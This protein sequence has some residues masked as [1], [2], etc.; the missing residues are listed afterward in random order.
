MKGSTISD[1][2]EVIS[3]VI[4]E[5]VAKTR[6]CTTSVSRQRK[7]HNGSEVMLDMLNETVLVRYLSLLTAAV[8]RGSL[9]IQ[10]HHDK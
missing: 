5:N 9:D 10:K 8:T 7:R 6:L 2:S 3:E 4:L 1:G